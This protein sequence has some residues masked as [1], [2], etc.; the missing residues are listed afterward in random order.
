MNTDKNSYTLIY[1]SVMVVLAAVMLAGAA[2]FF[3]EDQQ[4]NEKV[5][6]MEQILRSVGIEAENKAEIPNLYASSI[7]ASMLINAEGETVSEVSGSELGSDADKAFSGK[8]LPENSYPLFKA[9]VQGKDAFIIPVSGAGLWGNIWGYVAIDATDA[10]TILGVDFGNAGETPGLGAEM[11]TPL[12]SNRFPG[13][14][15]IKNGQF[16]SI[17]VV[18][19]GTHLADQ[20]YVD[21]LSGGTLTSDGIHAMLRDGLAPYKVFLETHNAN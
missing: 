9:V 21:G 17:A 8:N 15:L 10:S 7:K 1:A 4:K 16:K 20:D 5:D 13:K 11:S 12:F 2:V 19:P 18:K 6:K 14:Q 3:K